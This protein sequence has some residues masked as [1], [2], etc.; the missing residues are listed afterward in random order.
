MSQHQKEA[1]RHPIF[2]VILTSIIDLFLD[3][4]ANCPI[5]EMMM[6]SDFPGH[7]KRAGSLYT[8]VDSNLPVISASLLDFCIHFFALFCLALGLCWFSPLSSIKRLTVVLFLSFHQQFWCQQVDQGGQQAA[9]WPDQHR[10]RPP[11][12]PAPL[13][14]L[15]T[16][17]PLSTPADGPG[18]CLRQE[19]QLLPA[20]WE[21]I[22]GLHY[23][24]SFMSRSGESLSARGRNPTLALVAI[25]HHS[26]VI[27]LPCLLECDGPCGENDVSQAWLDVTAPHRSSLN[28]PGWILSI[29]VALQLGG[30]LHQLREEKRAT[31]THRQT[32]RCWLS[33]SSEY[34]AERVRRPPFKRDDGIHLTKGNERIIVIKKKGKEPDGMR[35]RERGRIYK[36]GKEYLEGWNVLEAHT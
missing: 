11:A 34:P 19:S 27:I 33:L 10:D 18:V 31:H 8:L 35:K 1:T 12:R 36:E 9:A 2:T 7:R 22:T 13:A 15:N 17:A 25:T 32:P 14:G 26:V 6:R 29:A 5:D 4:S 28:K 24:W 3:C 16:S 30:P 21:L 23:Q 20:R